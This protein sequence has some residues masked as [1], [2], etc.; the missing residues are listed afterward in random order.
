MPR[1]TTG[2]VASSVYVLVVA[3]LAL[4]AFTI[5]DGYVAFLW[6][7]IV[8]TFPAS[9]LVMLTF[10]ALG[11]ATAALGVSAPEW[12]LFIWVILTFAGAACLNVWLAGSLV[13]QR[14]LE[15]A[16]RPEQG[17]RQ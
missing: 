15:R 14:R 1:T 3:V 10:W 16:P 6:W 17:S 9:F 5:P 7:D 12:L 11:A 8:V 2:R 4:L 13:A